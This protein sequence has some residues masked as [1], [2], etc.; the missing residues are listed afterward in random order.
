MSKYTETIPDR[1]CA[2]TGIGIELTIVGF[3]LDVATVFVMRVFVYVA[4]GTI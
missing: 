2:A 1:P 4:S 3:A